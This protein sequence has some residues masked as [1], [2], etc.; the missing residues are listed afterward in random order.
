[1]DPEFDFDPDRNEFYVSSKV[2][3]S[4][5]ENGWVHIT[6]SSLLWN[7]VYSFQN[8][9]LILGIQNFLMQF[10][11]LSQILLKLV[12][13]V[14][15]TFWF[16]MWMIF[17]K[18]YVWWYGK[19]ILFQVFSK[20]I[21]YFFSIWLICWFDIDKTFIQFFFVNFSNKFWGNSFFGSLKQS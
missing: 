15:S 9:F 12:R 21:K 1:M 10:F 6:I 2:Q 18:N 14:I 5:D 16:N 17:W 4:F 13:I 20:F 3:S 7:R 8:S 19:D 11:G